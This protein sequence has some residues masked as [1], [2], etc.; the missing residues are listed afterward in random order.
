MPPEANEGYHNTSKTKEL[1]VTARG[2]KLAGP[3]QGKRIRFTNDERRRLDDLEV[4]SDYVE[5]QQRW[6]ELEAK[7]T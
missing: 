2:A 7:A 1:S 6:E 5:T 4:A 3:A